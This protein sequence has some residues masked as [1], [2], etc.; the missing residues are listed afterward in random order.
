LAHIT[1]SIELPEPVAV[2]SECWTE[3]ERSSRCAVG[4]ME[5][6]VRWR[7]EVLTLEPRGDGTRLTL[8]IDYEPALADP[9]LAPGLE[10]VLEGFRS[11]VIERIT[12]G[13]PAV[14][15]APGGWR[16]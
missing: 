1:R 15:P 3:F 10:G 14:A 8:R 13:W 9:A 6:R 12:G 5:A 4:V 2:V 11:F 7:R 16:S